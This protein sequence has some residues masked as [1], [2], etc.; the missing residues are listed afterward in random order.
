MRAIEPF[1]IRIPQKDL[2]DLKQ[3]LALT[4]FPEKETPD[5][6]SQGIPLAYVKEIKE[7]WQN[8]Y[9]WR[10]AENQINQ[11]PQFKT[12]IDDLGIH[13]LHVQSPERDALPLVMTH[14]W[15][16][17]IVEFLKVIPP[18]TDPVSHGGKASDAFHLVCPS[19]PGYGFSDKPA[20]PGW[21]VEKTADAWAELM[22]RLGYDAYFGQGG[23]WGAIV[24]TFI[25]AQDPEHCRAIHVNPPF[26]APDPDMMDDLTE[27]EQRALQLLERYWESGSGYSKQQST[28][29]QTI[30]YALSDSP[31][32]QMAWILEKFYEWTDCNGHPENAL[33]RDEM[34][35]NIML[36][37]LTGS[38]ASSARLYWESFDA[39]GTGKPVE[40]P[41]GVSIYPKEVIL[42]SPRWAANIYKNITYWNELDRGGHFA[43]F[44]QPALFVAEL[45]RFFR[46]FR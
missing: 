38:G 16:G 17:S 13:F 22:R 30:G 3:R 10:R 39:V 45:R 34:L 9:D 27:F 6:W 19:L 2:D 43:A 35:D 14:G 12:T 7:Y 32:G 37:W 15:P 18:L 29:P 20:T 46:S 33:G 11:F 26:A 4:R 40:I 42:T 5:D 8:R 28:R 1:Q 25:G 44:E 41:T 23:D 21:G 24:T 31:V 36:Y